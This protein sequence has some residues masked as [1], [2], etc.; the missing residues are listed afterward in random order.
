MTI[1]I[2]TREKARAIQQIKAEFQKQNIDTITSKLWVGDYARIDNL[3]TVIDRKQNLLELASNVIEKRFHNEVKRAS[4]HGIKIIFLVEHGR[5]IRD[6]IDVLF[7]ENPRKAESPKCI[8]G[9]HL[10][11][12]MNTMTERY[13]VEWQFCQKR[14]TGKRIIEILKGVG[15]DS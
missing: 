15:N 10:F 1:Q 3:S 5:N 7:W 13:G 9:E 8:S 2:D 4:E 12:A 14:D 6:L 11:K